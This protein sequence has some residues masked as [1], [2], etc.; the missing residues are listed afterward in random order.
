[1]S[2]KAV[3]D[4]NKALKSKGNVIKNKHRNIKIKHLMT[5][6]MRAL[7]NEAKVK[8]LNRTRF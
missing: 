4:H 2:I 6:W 1:M 8:V 5:I 3:K 7:D